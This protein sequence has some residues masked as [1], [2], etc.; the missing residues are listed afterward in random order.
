MDANAFKWVQR[1]ASHTWS[2]WS[3]W[4]PFDNAL[5]FFN[6]LLTLCWGGPP[7]Q[8]ALVTGYATG[9]LWTIPVIV[10]GMW[11]TM[12]A[13]MIAHEVKTHWKR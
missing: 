13:T 8:P 10:Q 7:D 1:L 3:Y 4:E 2:T 5:V 12:I 6:A 11:T 9:V